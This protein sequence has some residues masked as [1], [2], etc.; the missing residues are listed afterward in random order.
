MR[1]TYPA[2]T[3]SF[4]VKS[5]NLYKITTPSYTIE[6]YKIGMFDENDERHFNAILAF[7]KEVDKTLM[8]ESIYVA[9]GTCMNDK[10]P[11]VISFGGL[12]GKFDINIENED[13][14]DKDV[15]DTAFF[16]LKQC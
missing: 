11:I 7:E 10:Q 14:I 5:N 2:H 16:Y 4:E 8:N 9:Q 1:F 13:A 3:I 6:T 15:H 12:I